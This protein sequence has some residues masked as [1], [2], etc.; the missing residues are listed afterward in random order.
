MMRRASALLLAAFA[1]PAFGQGGGCV[2]VTNSP[3][4][5]RGVNTYINRIQDDNADNQSV[6]EKPKHFRSALKTL[7]ESDRIEN[8]IGRWYMT[9]LVYASYLASNAKNVKDIVVR[10][11]VGFYDNPK[12]MHDLYAAV[13]S[14]LNKVEA[15]NSACVDSTSVVRFRVYRIPF[16]KARALMNA[17]KYDSAE[18]VAKRAL[19]VDPKSGAPWNLIAEVR[20]RKGDTPGYMAALDQVI[21][22]LGSDSTAKAVR[23]QALFNLAV[24]NSNNA[25]KEVVDEA[26]R[27]ELARKAVGYFNEFLKIKVNDPPGRTALARALKLAGDSAAAYAIFKEMLVDPTR[28]TATQLFS[29]GVDAFGAQRY[30]DAIAFFDAGLKKNPNSRDGLFNLANS[31]VYAQNYD[32]ALP[33]FT[34]LFAVDPLNRD[35][36]ILAAKT[37]Q[38]IQNGP[39]G[40]RKATAIDSTV[41]YLRLRDSSEFTVKPDVFTPP[42]TGDF[43]FEG[44]VHNMTAAPKSFSFIVEFLNAAGNVVGSAQTIDVAD[45]PAKTGKRFSITGRGAGVVAYRYKKAGS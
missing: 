37:W 1:T 22:S 42:A 8:Q 44:A 3:A 10:E 33:L 28:Y 41:Y 34:R 26:K 19:V 24:L 17:G 9:G 7:G 23:S 43:T 4:Q 31:Y 18:I 38:S 12:G 2:I 36:Y 45:I 40:P 6:S 39:D 25:E 20:Q 16:N 21:S 5:L 29:A 14:A 35:N 27:A 30:D 32:L 13:D 11:D 15:M